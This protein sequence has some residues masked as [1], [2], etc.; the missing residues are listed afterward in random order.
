MPPAKVII[1]DAEEEDE[2]KKEQERRELEQRIQKQVQSQYQ[3]HIDE[4]TAKVNESEAHVSSLDAELKKKSQEL[5]EENEKYTELLD[6]M[7]HRNMKAE[8]TIKQH[9]KQKELDAMRKSAVLMTD[10]IHGLSRRSSLVSNAHTVMTHARS[11][12]EEVDDGRNLDH[13]EQENEELLQA[14][15]DLR[16]QLDGAQT[17]LDL[18]E[19]AG[20]HRAKVPV[21]Q[22]GG[23]EAAGG[24]PTGNLTAAQRADAEAL[25][26]RLER[27]RNGIEDGNIKLQRQR[28]LSGSNPVRPAGLEDATPTPSYWES[29]KIFA[30]SCLCCH[31]NRRKVPD[32]P[33]ALPPGSAPVV[34]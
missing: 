14:V 27:V 15:L 33:W 19:Q 16:S 13:L 34:F 10:S 4:L 29:G 31:T 20:E 32:L 30:L 9:E 12:F 8:N 11:I 2:E 23:D 26:T 22:G 17:Q 6:E 24:Q 3:E 18:M 1:R 28:R 25:I 5:S 21:Q 7:S